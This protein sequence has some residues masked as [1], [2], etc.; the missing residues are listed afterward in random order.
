M[1]QQ[2]YGNEYIQQ[3]DEWIYCI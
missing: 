2:S 1:E 3:K